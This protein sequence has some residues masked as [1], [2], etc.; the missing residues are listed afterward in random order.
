M[1][2]DKYVLYIATFET[3]IISTSSINGLTY[4][5]FHAALF[6]SMVYFSLFI[7]FSP[8]CVFK[9]GLLMFSLIPQVIKAVAKILPNIQTLFLENV[10]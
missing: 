7:I 8:L 3:C 5:L 4:S 1:A 2:S 9:F 6:I 10:T